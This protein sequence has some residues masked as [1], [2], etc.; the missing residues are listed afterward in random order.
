MNLARRCWEELYEQFHRHGS[1]S[2]RSLTNHLKRQ[3]PELA[4]SGHNTL[5]GW[6]KTCQSLP[7]KLVFL[8]LAKTLELDEQEW[9]ERWEQ[10]DR[11]RYTA[12]RNSA[13]RI[14]APPEPTAPAPRDERQPPVLLI[15]VG[16]LCGILGTLGGLALA[17]F[18]GN[19]TNAHAPSGTDRLPVC[20]DIVSQMAHVFPAPGDEAYKKIAKYQGEQV[21]LYP[22]APDTVGSDGR[23]Y[24]AVRSPARADPGRYPYSWM[25]ADDLANAPCR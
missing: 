20:A 2:L 4:P 6:F 13:G 19:S 14:P 22:G 17:A 1:W 5:K 10:W 9:S 25:L 8:E 11:A 15:G 23:R 12:A 7:D 3:C 21:V 24:R 16:V 18:A